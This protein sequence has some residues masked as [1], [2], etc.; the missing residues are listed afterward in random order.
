MQRIEKSILIDASPAQVW[1]VASDYSQWHT[2]FV[3]LSAPRSV[4][5]EGGLG[6]V[7]EHTV[8]VYNIPMPLK[9]TVTTCDLD[10]CWRG[11]FAGPMTK[12]SQEWTYTPGQ[13]GGTE[14]KLV[15]ETELMGPAKLAEKMVIKAF[16]T[17]AGQALT[18]LKAR[19]EGA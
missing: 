17:M 5:G 12:G 10:A 9:T 19:V 2:W 13:G 3:G 18:N 4:A 1:T 11:E 14:V 15:M 8:T 6:T 16:D 7:I